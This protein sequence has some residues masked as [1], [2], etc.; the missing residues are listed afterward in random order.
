[1]KEQ[2]FGAVGN[3]RDDNS[4][5]KMATVVFQTQHHM[6]SAESDDEGLWEKLEADKTKLDVYKE[7]RRN[8]HSQLNPL[9]KALTGALEDGRNLEILNASETN[10]T[11]KLTV[12]RVKPRVIIAHTFIHIIT[13]SI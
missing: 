5:L 7:D 8:V 13:H 1:L 9:L 6:T 2:I 3:L 11:C 4:I 12:L 10:S